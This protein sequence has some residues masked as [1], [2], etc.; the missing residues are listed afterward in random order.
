MATKGELTNANGV[1][2][3]APQLQLP[4]DLLRVHALSS[5]RTTQGKKGEAT[6]M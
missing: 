1:R 3:V 2:R 4:P 5:R 6:K